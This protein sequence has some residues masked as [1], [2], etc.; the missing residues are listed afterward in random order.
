MKADQPVINLIEA[1][2]CHYQFI[3]LN[4]KWRLILMSFVTF[5]FVEKWINT[6]KLW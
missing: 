4:K 3:W 1:N 5:L 6:E 2:I